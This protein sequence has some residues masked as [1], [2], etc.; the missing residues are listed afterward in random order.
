MARIRYTEK[1]LQADI[2]EL[3]ETLKPSGYFL[4]VDSRNGYTAIDEYRADSTKASGAACVRNIECGTPREC[5]D[6]ACNYEPPQK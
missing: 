5:W 4:R 2:R 1:A 3:N 6:A